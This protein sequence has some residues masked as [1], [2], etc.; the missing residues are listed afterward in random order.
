MSVPVHIEVDVLA[1]KSSGSSSKNTALVAGH[2]KAS[3]FNDLGIGLL[4]VDVH[5][6]TDLSDQFPQELSSGEQFVGYMKVWDL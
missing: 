6:H 1:S 3:S 4:S 2:T 5:Y